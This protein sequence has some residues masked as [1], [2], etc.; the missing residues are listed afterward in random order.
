MIKTPSTSSAKPAVIFDFGGVLLDWDPRYL[1]RKIFNGDIAGMER[2]LADIDFMDWNQHQDQGRPFDEGV[3][4]LSQQFPHYADLIQ[5]YHQRWEESIIG[6]IDTTVK[7]LDSLK[8]GGYPL[9]GLSNFSIEKFEIARRK[10]P[11]FAWFDDIL[12][13]AQV[14]LL[15]PDH[16]IFLHLLEKVDRK[17]E[18]CIF[19]DDSP[20]NVSAAGSLGMC[21]IH[22]HDP[23]QLRFDLE[24]CIRER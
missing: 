21:A 6:P 17:P 13:S 3:A 9:Y 4:V 24:T 2:F 16:R 23:E 1:Y 19:I 5:A 10:Y 11:F 7:I 20:S 14:G 8:R 22:Y 15:K 12:L 18:D